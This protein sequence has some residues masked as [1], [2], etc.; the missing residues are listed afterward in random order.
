MNELVSIIITTYNRRE[1]ILEAIGS[2]LRQAYPHIEIIV[3]DD[4]STDDTKAILA[5]LIKGQKI[6]YHYKQNAERAAARN[7]GMKL[8]SGAFLKFLDSDDL[9]EEGY[10]DACLKCFLDEKEVMLVHTNCK[11]MDE[12]GLVT[13]SPKKGITGNVYESLWADNDISLSSV[14][15]RKKVLELY[16]SFDETLTLSGAEDWEYWI[17]LAKQGCIVGFVTEYVTVIRMHSSN[18]TMNDIEK[19]LFSLDVGRNLLQQ[20][21]EIAPRLIAQSKSREIYLKAIYHYINNKRVKSVGNLSK[22]VFIAPQ[23]LFFKRTW[24]L[25]FKNFIP[26]PLVMRLKKVFPN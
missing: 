20:K 21:F 19:I 13:M 1:F 15:M 14:M 24:A 22:L 5:D 9:I 10:V 17:R 25:F 3:V 7:T 2:C 23:F 6:I 11:V 26:R 8:A 16:G 12:K 18:G 4:G